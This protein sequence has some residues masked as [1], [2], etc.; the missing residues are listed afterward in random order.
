MK[1]VQRQLTIVAIARWL[2]NRLVCQSTPSIPIA[3]SAWLM[4]PYWSP[5]RLPKMIATATGE[6]TYGSRMLIRQMVRPR[7]CWSSSAASTTAITICGPEDST[8]M[9]RVLTVC[10]RK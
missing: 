10:L 6:T 7:R 8:K 4:R 2:A 1:P 9:L 5:K 3:S